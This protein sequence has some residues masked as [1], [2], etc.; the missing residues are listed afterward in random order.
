VK[1]R[2]VY[3]AVVNMERGQNVVIGLITAVLLHAGQY[4][5]ENQTGLILPRAESDTRGLTLQPSS[6]F[7]LFTRGVIHAC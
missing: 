6:T 2:A 4:K 3:T 5:T 1:A 7:V